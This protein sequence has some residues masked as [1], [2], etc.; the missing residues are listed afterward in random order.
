VTGSKGRERLVSGL[1]DSA[2]PDQDGPNEAQG[3]AIAVSRE[4][5]E[6][7]TDRRDHP[8]PLRREEHTATLDHGNPQVRSD[9]RPSLS[10]M[11]TGADR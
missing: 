6:N 5:I 1:C 11:S 7:W 4:R 2:S 10:S 8:T 3:Q 9:P